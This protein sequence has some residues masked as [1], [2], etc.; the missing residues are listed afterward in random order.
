M[1]G[2]ILPL[3]QALNHIADNGIFW[4]WT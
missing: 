3:D 1:G 4:T 2:C